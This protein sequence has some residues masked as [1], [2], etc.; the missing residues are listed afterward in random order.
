MFSVVR[1]LIRSTDEKYV[2]FTLRR[3]VAQEITVAYFFQKKKNVRVKKKQRRD[4][5]FFLP[6][7]RKIFIIPVKTDT[8]V[9][10]TDVNISIRSEKSFWMLLIRLA[11]T[12]VLQ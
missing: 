10:S 2:D 8:F 9:N 1:T 6:T 12:L 7:F 5:G 4:V 3:S 11:S